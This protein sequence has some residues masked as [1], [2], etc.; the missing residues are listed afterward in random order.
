MITFLIPGLSLILTSRQSRHLSSLTGYDYFFDSGTPPD[1]S[2]PL[3]PSPPVTTPNFSGNDYYYDY[4]D[5]A[6]L[7]R[8]DSR[9]RDYLKIGI[10]HS[11]ILKPRPKLFGFPGKIIKNLLGFHWERNN[12]RPPTKAA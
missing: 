11:L 4:G 10:R 9:N 7:L 5:P 1:L 6:D 12:L 8:R 3:A 2:L